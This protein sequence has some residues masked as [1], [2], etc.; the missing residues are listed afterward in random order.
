MP[1]K[2]DGL[3]FRKIM[4]RT[5]GP[6]IY[7]AWVLMLAVAAKSQPVRGWLAD[8]DRPY[9]AADL[10]LKTGCAASAFETALNV[11]SSK[12]I[13][14][15][16]VA[17][18]EHAPST[19]QD[20]TGQD[21]DCCAVSAEL[22][23]PATSPAADASEFVFPTTG[24]GPKEWTLPKSKLSEYLAAYPGLDVLAE[25]R[26]ARQ[27]CRDNPRNR[28]TAAK[29]KAF[30]TGWLNRSQNRGGRKSGG[31][32][33]AYEKVSAEEFRRFLE[34]RQF[35]EKPTRNAK[36]PRWV[37]GTLRDGRRVECRDYP[38]PDNALARQMDGR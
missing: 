35:E 19:L 23:Q 20:R 38:L 26:H 5:D 22:P 31:E 12:E 8:A 28:K 3:S 15:I 27:W 33:Q 30:L 34:D 1:T 16:V 10:E 14:W 37:F 17:E 21:K 7:T 32:Q 25:L 11:L 6:M 18:W 29:M 4:A 36:D 13:G 9:D 24:Q 2:H